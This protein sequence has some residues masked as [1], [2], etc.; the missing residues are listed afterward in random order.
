MNK[1]QLQNLIFVANG[2]KEADLV[3]RNAQIVNVFTK[4]IMIGDIAIAE[5]VIAGIGTYK[6]KV[7]IDA[8]GRYVCPGLI[9]AHVHIESSMVTPG[10]FAKVVLPHGVTTVIA[11]PHE[12][13]NVHGTT[14]IQF[15]LDAS[16]N[17]PLDVYMMLPSCVPATS[18]EQAGAVLHAEDL[19][20]FLKHPR[21]LGLAEVMDFPAV[22]EAKD[23]M[24]NK[25]LLTNCID[26][27]GA[28]L[29]T[30]HINVYRAAGITTDHECTTKEEM[31]DRIE[32]GM[33]VMLREGSVA[34]NVEALLEA[35]TEKNAYRCLFCTDDKH[36]DDL[37]EEGSIDYNVRFA[38]KKGIAPITAI[39]MA[40]FYAAQ[41]YGL[42]TK[43]AVAPGYDADFL[44]LDDLETFSIYEVYTKGVRV[45]AN[46]QY[47]G[48]EM[49][50]KQ[51]EAVT[52]SVYLP[53][54]SKKDL[55]LHMGEGMLA[56]IIGIVSNQLITKHIIEAVT[57]EK[58]YFIPSV[59]DDQL[60]IAVV[61]RY[62]ATG[63]IGIGIVKGFGLQSGAIATTVAHDSHNIIA[64]GTNDGDLL[65]AITTIHNI[66][67]GMVVVNNGVVL[68]QLSLNIA[69]LMSEEGSE[70]V[71][72]KITAINTSLQQLGAQTE[73][74]PFL[75]LS[76]LSLPV[77]PHLKMTVDGLFDVVKFEHISVNIDRT[78]DEISS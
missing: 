51:H 30:Q 50:E 16:E 74:N 5:G 6:G 23:D 49:K 15:M 61:E 64:V 47:V 25:L 9:D 73:F 67:G 21:V 44:L 63:Q 43:G 35:V 75:T 65:Q 78:V 34:K 3:I 54:I 33:Y 52:N 46:G 17:L 55:Q 1:Q 29:S 42:K 53:A 36:L 45:A 19:S 56:N 20:P 32:R 71:Y 14:G 18:F 31:L 76:F 68:E 22:F 66:Q 7:E 41:C 40:S 4:E 38:I 58:G 24:L 10:Q 57:I 69:G 37:I 11:D 13:A 28:G 77:I 8:K 12:I 62:K 2:T 72:K 48:E 59:R 39:S 27:H 26:G 70:F 60:K